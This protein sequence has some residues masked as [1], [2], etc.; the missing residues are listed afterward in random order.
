MQGGVLKCACKEGKAPSPD[1]QDPAQSTLPMLLLPS[2]IMISKFEEMSIHYLD[3]RLHD[4]HSKVSSNYQRRI[5][6]RYKDQF[7]PQ[8]AIGQ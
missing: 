3:V 5:S 7:P 2:P 8:W 4:T 6:T 1:R